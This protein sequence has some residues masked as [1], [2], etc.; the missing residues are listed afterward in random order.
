MALKSLTE[1]RVD[2]AMAYLAET[3]LEIASWRGMVM[4]T[5][6]LLEVAEAMAFKLLDGGVEERKKAA[7]CTDEVR[8]ATEDVIKSTIEF[9]KLKARRQREVLVIELYRSV[10]SARKVGMSI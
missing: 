8:K 7:K 1:D 2:Q 9:E 3:D 10:L 6:Y 5:E 4:R